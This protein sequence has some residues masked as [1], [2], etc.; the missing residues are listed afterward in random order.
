[1][2]IK[3]KIKYLIKELKIFNKELKK[4]KKLHVQKREEI[5]KQIKNGGTK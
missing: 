3:N 4:E 2:N 5:E 1:M